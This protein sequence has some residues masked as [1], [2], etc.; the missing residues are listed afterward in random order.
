MKTKT[1]VSIIV[2]ATLVTNN[3]LQSAEGQKTQPVTPAEAA[4]KKP[5]RTL[6]EIRGAITTVQA[7]IDSRE[8]RVKRLSDQIVELDTNVEQGVDRILNLTMNIGDSVDSNTRVTQVKGNIIEGLKSSVEVYNRKRSSLRQDV[9]EN[10]KPFSEKDVKQDMKK[11]DSQIDK[12]V[13]QIIEISKT[14]QEHKDFPK[15]TGWGGYGW[16]G[17]WGYHEKNPKYK[18]NRSATV[19]TDKERKNLVEALKESI[20]SLKQQNKDLERRMESCAFASQKTLMEEDLER[21]KTTIKMRQAQLDATLTP[22]KKETTP[23]GRFQALEVEDTVREIA[24]D[25]QRDFDSMFRIYQEYSQ[26]RELLRRY[27]AQMASLHKM[28]EEKESS[29]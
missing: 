7:R 11:L 26:Q 3:A 6:E 22:Q 2:T 18:Q 8:K 14:L 12:R 1:I 9:V 16:R 13:N 19:L 17:G 20:E 5:E 15:F 21:N 4:E 23:V 29:N 28:L 24:T 25:I 27:E 10:R